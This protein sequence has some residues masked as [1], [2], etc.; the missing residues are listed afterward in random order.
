[1]SRRISIL[2]VLLFFLC[3][4][5]QLRSKPLQV[6]AGGT[7]DRFIGT[8]QLVSTEYRMAD[9]SK[10]PYPDVGPHGKGYLIYTADGHMCAELMNPDRPAWKKDSAPTP[11][12]KIS[13]FDGLAAYCG[14]F[15]IDEAHGMM[16]HLPEVAWKPGFVG[17]RQPRPFSFDGDLLIFSD[18]ETDEP[19]AVSYAI[20]WRKV[21]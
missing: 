2:A 13:A 16:Y 7:A 9:G 14:R 12:E 20:T 1:M 19:G 18:K 21:K 5:A 4:F 8:W 6:S 10:R 17:T 11:E 15:E 3:A